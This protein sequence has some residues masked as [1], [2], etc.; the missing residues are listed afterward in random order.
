MDQKNKQG[1]TALHLSAKVGAVECISKLFELGLTFK[2][3][4]NE[5]LKF[6]EYKSNDIYPQVDSGTLDGL[7][8][9]CISTDFAG[10]SLLFFFE[11]N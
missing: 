10:L 5:N 11:K 2:D 6:L 8:Q 7:I 9:Q 3:Y 4:S 1:L